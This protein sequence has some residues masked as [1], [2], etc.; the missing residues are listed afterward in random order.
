MV[1]VCT[2]RLHLHENTSYVDTHD[3]GD[4]LERWTGGHYKSTRHRVV[5]P[6]GTARFSCPFFFEPNFNTLVEVL[7]GYGSHTEYPPVTSGQYLLRKYAATHE[8]YRG[9]IECSSA[10]TDEYL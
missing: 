4:M 2:C 1:L 5:N 10:K 7:P 3:A 6:K 9:K 8:D